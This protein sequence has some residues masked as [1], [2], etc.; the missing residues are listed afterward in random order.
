MYTKPKKKEQQNNKHKE[1]GEMGSSSDK[2]R[3]V[4]IEA[5]KASPCPYLECTG[6]PTKIRL[7]SITG[8]RGPDRGK[9]W[10]HCLNCGGSGPTKD[11]EDEAIT[12][13]NARQ[14][15]INWIERRKS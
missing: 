12:A 10:I 11:S 7:L 15:T 14:A 13:W 6:K 8:E 5:R 4:D 3:V 2:S 9:T 1:G